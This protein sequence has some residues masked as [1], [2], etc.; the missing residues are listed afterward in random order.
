[1]AYVSTFQYSLVNN[2]FYLT[3]NK[4]SLTENYRVDVT[5]AKPTDQIKAN[6][7]YCQT[8]N[9][10]GLKSLKLR[11]ILRSFM[12]L[13]LIKFLD[14]KDKVIEISTLK[15]CTNPPIWRIS[16]GF[17]KIALCQ[18]SRPDVAAKL[19]DQQCNTGK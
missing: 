17:E 9:I 1:M 6:Q 18:H 12:I 7:V 5:D 3:I 2:D 8:N 10:L 14:D 19:V 15:M 4:H 13:I 11:N 16:I